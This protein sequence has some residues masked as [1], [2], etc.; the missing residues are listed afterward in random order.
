M[1]LIKNKVEPTKVN[2]KGQEISSII[3]DELQ[4]YCE[5]A[6]ITSESLAIEEALAY[7]FKSDKEWKAAKKAKATDLA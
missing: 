7:V 3:Y 1:P 4:Q 2:L 6:G 5:W